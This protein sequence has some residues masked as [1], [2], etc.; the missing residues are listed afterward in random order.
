MIINYITFMAIVQSPF[1]TTYYKDSFVNVIHN[2]VHTLWQ[3]II[4]IS[5][6]RTIKPLFFHNPFVISWRLNYNN[7][8]SKVYTL[9]NHN[10]NLAFYEP[11]HHNE[12]YAFCCLD[13]IITSSIYKSN[14][15]KIFL[16]H[17]H[18]NINKRWEGRSFCMNTSLLL[19]KITVRIITWN[20][21]NTKQMLW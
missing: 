8:R 18:L 2:L 14:N 17:E 3:H 16:C 19:T 13:N 21:L 9:Y 6:I 20:E 11:Q 10:G 15:E 7:N 12:E 5:H 1:S 4:N